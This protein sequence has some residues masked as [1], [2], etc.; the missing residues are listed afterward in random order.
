MGHWEEAETRVLRAVSDLSSVALLLCLV[1]GGRI[2][3]WRTQTTQ[4][5]LPGFES[6][7]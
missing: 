5:D 1:I 7:L 3:W 6:Q 2:Q 4:P